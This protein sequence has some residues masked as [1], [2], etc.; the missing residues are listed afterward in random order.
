MVCD[1]IDECRCYAYSD[2]SDTKRYQFC[3]VRRGPRI[4]DCPVDCCPGGCPGNGNN[5]EPREPFRII[6]RPQT[7]EHSTI[8]KKIVLIFVYILSLLT[9]MLYIT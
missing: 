6:K 7:S 9:F 3:G 8:D 4:I 1:F 5:I 2:V